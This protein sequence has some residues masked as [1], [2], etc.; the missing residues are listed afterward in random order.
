MSL[1]DYANWFL[2]W[3]PAVAV[4]AISALP[5]AELRVGLPL[6]LA[7]FKLDLFSAVAWSLLG[8]IVPVILIL[9][10]IGPV[11]A[12]LSARSKW[13]KSFFHWLFE[14]TRKKMTAQ[15]EKYGWWALMIFVGLPLPMTGGWTGALAA[16]LFGLEK[17]KSFFFI[18]LG[19]CLA[20]LI[21][22]AAW[23]GVLGVWGQWVLKK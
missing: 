15:Y 4:V 3:P 11:S 21:V 8:N 10:F 7:V 17:K 12:C 22:Y 19:L 18:F 20:E 9:Y 2:G 14:R 13:F 1:I 16:W 5:V 23:S 6:A